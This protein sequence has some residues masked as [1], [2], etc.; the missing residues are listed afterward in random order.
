[1]NNLYPTDQA[2]IA[3]EFHFTDDHITQTS[4]LAF[5]KINSYKLSLINAAFCMNRDELAGIIQNS[6]LNYTTPE[7]V[8]ADQ[9]FFSSAMNN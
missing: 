1:M 5:L 3:D 8:L 2:Y 9:G 4:R 7:N 6:L